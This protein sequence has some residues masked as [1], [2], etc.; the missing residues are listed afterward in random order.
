M[1]SSATLGAST[2][3][4][5]SVIAQASITVGSLVQVQGSMVALVAAITLDT[6]TL[7]SASNVC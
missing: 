2:K 3:L 7:T 5:G 6:N 1:G 4:V